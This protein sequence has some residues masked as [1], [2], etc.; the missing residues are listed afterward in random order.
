MADYPAL[1]LFI[2]DRWCEG[3][4]RRTEPVLN[5]A[6]GA[7]LGELPHATDADLDEALASSVKGHEVWRKTSPVERARIRQRAAALIIER[8]E[9]IARLIT[10]EL[11]KPIA[12]I[13]R[14]G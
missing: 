6:T 10:L 12:E 9:N 13:P 8:A 5:P 3:E 1:K 14:R 4:G 2:N 7:V 11:G